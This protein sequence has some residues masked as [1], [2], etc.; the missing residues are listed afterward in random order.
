MFKALGR[1][2]RHRNYR[3]FFTGQAVSLVGTW[4]TRL[5]TSWL[6][7]RLTADP[8][9]LGITNF[10]GLVPSFV[11]GPLCGVLVDRVAD[12]K[13]LIF[14]TQLA[15]MLQSLA[16][17][18]IA[19][20]PLPADVAVGLLVG[21]SVAQGVINAVDVPARQAFLPRMVPD[22]A[23]LANGIALNSTL[24]N[25]ARLVGPAIAG[26]LIGVI[27]EIGCFAVDALSY[28]GVLWALWA[29]R[30]PNDVSET[31]V[32][33]HRPSFWAGLTEGVSYTYKHPSIR[34]L[35]VLVAVLSLLGMPYTV[36]LPI[37]AKEI[38]HGGPHT[39]GLLTSA[40]GLGAV[41]AALVL[42]GRKSTKDFP[43]WI[44]GSG[45]VFAATL[46]GFAYSTTLKLSVILLALAG[47]G[48]LMQTASCSTI[49]QTV[50]EPAKRGRVMSLY[51]TAFLGMAPFGSL[52]IG[53]LAARV[54]PAATLAGCAGLC[55][56]STLF[57]AKTFRPPAAQA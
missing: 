21:L 45:V 41:A 3:L 55:L 18:A 11:L 49:I 35:I 44:V 40:A 42:A 26:G 14:R 27:G 38:L 29:M 10:A 2:L 24:F 54:G 30:L 17:V 43:R 51:S 50:V 34:T 56:L 33:V 12:L 4:M 19:A 36:L 39:L 57:F 53:F 28:V 1:S 37:Y 47:F 25:A 13:K 7:Y 9:W 46:A 15:G 22:A 23:D 8:V 5:A 48:M 32:A 31:T 6:V 20:A 52:A 16:L